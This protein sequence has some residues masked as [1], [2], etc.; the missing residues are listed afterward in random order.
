MSDHDED[1]DHDDADPGIDC[2]PAADDP[3]CFGCMS[4]SLHQEL[5]GSAEII[6]AKIDAYEEL[7]AQLVDNGTVP[8]SRA[9]DL[10]LILGLAKGAV[11]LLEEVSNY[12]E[13]CLNS[14]M[15]GKLREAFA[16]APVIVVHEKGA[17]VLPV[18][19]DEEIDS[20]DMN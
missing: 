10:G 5:K 19:D 4:A 13:D 15:V 12:W 6:E 2:T 18:E 17:E 9:L 7:I 20:K 3:H 8:A 16:N 11:T 14:L 1:F